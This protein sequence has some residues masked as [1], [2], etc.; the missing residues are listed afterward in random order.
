MLSNIGVSAAM[1][2]EIIE[3]EV[4]DNKVKSEIKKVDEVL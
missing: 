4:K 1:I 2:F 3:V